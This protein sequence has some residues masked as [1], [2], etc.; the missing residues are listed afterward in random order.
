MTQACK[1]NIE[2]GQ[3]I[4]YV[5]HFLSEKGENIV[6]VRAFLGVM[7]YCRNVEIKGESVSWL[8]SEQVSR[9]SGRYESTHIQP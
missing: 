8:R 4:F 5:R 7:T 2:K 9:R 3:Y 6:P 1:G